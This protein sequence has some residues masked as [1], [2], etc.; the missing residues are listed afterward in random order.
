MKHVMISFSVK[1]EELDKVKA[2]IGEFISAIHKYET[3]TLMYK[4]FQ[5][6]TNPTRFIHIMTFKDDEAM[7][8]HRQTKHCREF[9]DRL[10]PLC[11]ELP[12]ANLYNEIR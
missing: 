9:V 6:S 12:V 2:I 10:Y 5:N 4:S 8:Y 11:A 3:D 1:P 7:D